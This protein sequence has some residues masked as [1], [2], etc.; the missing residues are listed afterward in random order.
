MS[1][2]H[3]LVP[4]KAL[5]LAK[6]RLAHALGPDDRATLV[7]AMLEDTLRAVLATGEIDVTVITADHDV[8]ATSRR[9]GVRVLADPVATGADDPLNSA[10][11]AAADLVR[12]EQPD[13]RLIALQADLPALRPGELSEALAVASETGFAIV[14]DHTGEGTAAWLHCSPGELSPLLFGPD[15]ARRHI[16]AG[17]HPVT[18][19]VPGLRLDVDTIDDLAG[20][21][22]LGVGERTSRA[23]ERL[24]I[25]DEG[26]ATGIPHDPAST[27]VR[28]V[29]ALLRG[30]SGNEPL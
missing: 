24:A 11:R 26:Y 4:V 7:L 13:T 22:R 6:S 3:A 14:A 28:P 30:S 5:G 15:S 2:T 18:T 20:A 21:V 29:E 9:C 17:A 25:T 16:E 12:R 10:L 23:L 19:A 1:A 27:G 8:A